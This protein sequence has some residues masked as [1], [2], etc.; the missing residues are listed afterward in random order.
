MELKEG[1][2]EALEVV[3][4]AAEKENEQAQAEWEAF[5]KPLEI[6]HP[7]SPAVM[8]EWWQEVQSL[9]EQS[10]NIQALHSEQKMDEALFNTLQAN[11]QKALGQQGEVDNWTTLIKSAHRISQSKNLIEETRQKQKRSQLR[12]RSLKE[13]VQ[14]FL[15]E[16]D[17]LLEKL[18]MESGSC[19]DTV[20]PV[21]HSYEELFQQF[22]EYQ[23][24]G[25]E[26]AAEE[27]LREAYS[28]CVQEL[29]KNFLAKE[30]L[31]NSTPTQLARHLANELETAQQ[32]QSSA[33]VYDQQIQETKR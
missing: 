6:N 11:L 33:K 29:A 26:L 13:K 14:N 28:R 24:C 5:W 12:V 19:V 8:L 21:V 18:G 30:I 16:W 1:K 4:Q 27:K 10:T 22:Q 23:K 31:E 20:R 15:P 25:T 9:Q 3:V 7:G 17:G 32:N 2:T